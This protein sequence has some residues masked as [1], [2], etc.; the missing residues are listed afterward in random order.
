MSPAECEIRAIIAL[1][2]EIEP[3]VDRVGGRGSALIDQCIRALWN[4][5]SAPLSTDPKA[6]QRAETLWMVAQIMR[7]LKLA[8]DQTGE[9]FGSPVASAQKHSVRRHVRHS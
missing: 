2:L 5:A 6:I 8:P 4:R 7:A 1:L 3:I 9:R